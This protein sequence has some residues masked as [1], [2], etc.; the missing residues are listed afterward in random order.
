MATDLPA[1]LAAEQKA[2]QLQEALP[3]PQF[4]QEQNGHSPSSQSPTSANG[5]GITAAASITDANLAAA[6]LQDKLTIKSPAVP[7]DPMPDSL[8]PFL[9]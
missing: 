6:V 4:Q 9:Q 3:A 7:T 2:A 5:I 8:K 1:P